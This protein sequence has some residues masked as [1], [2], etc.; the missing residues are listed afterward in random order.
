MFDIN[1]FSWGF[2]WPGSAEAGPVLQHA[3][4]VVA[5]GVS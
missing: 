2:T 1:L 4:E 5:D 3:I